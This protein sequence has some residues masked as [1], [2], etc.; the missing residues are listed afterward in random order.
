MFI[1]IDTKKKKEKLILYESELKHLDLQ[2][3]Y[4]VLIHF[5]NGE[6]ILRNNRQ[7]GGKVLEKMGQ[8][9]ETQEENYR[10]LKRH[11]NGFMLEEYY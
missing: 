2:P 5:N 8:C 10:R 11:E 6:L 7:P 1:N 3:G 9:G 4:Y